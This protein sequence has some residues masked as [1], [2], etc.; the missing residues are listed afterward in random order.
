MR[1][2]HLEA[3][4]LMNVKK[5]PQQSASW[6]ARE[7]FGS[8]N[9]HERVLLRKCD[10]VVSRVVGQIETRPTDGPRQNETSQTQVSV[11]RTAC[12]VTQPAPSGEV[13]LHPAGSKLLLIRQVVS[14][15]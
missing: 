10:S 2:K 6:H 14:E 11:Q 8:K 7:T 4:I 13:H 5:K 9:T 1:A 3:K 12:L 15:Y